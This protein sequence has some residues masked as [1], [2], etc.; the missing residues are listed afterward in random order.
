LPNSTPTS[1]PEN[2]LNTIPDIKHLTG[3]MR[4]LNIIEESKKLTKLKKKRRRELFW[5]INGMPTPL[6]VYIGFYTGFY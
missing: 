3:V 2:V 1:V 4:D 6:A 5:Y